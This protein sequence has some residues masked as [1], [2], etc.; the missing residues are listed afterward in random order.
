MSGFDSATTPE[1][2]EFSILSSVS[3]CAAVL[4]DLGFGGCVMVVQGW[5]MELSF[6]M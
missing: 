1:R 4:V 2:S 3:C 5:T 6:D